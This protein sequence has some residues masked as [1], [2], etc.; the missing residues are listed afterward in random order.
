MYWFI[1]LPLELRREEDRDSRGEKRKRNNRKKWREHLGTFFYSNNEKSL[2]VTYYQWLIQAQTNWQNMYRVVSHKLGLKL[3]RI[4][5]I[6]SLKT[7][8]WYQLKKDLS[9]SHL[10]EKQ[11]FG[12]DSKSSW[13]SSDHFQLKGKASRVSISR[14]SLNCSAFET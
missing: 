3:K 5:C 12:H 14:G 4:W 13:R 7:L 9:L 8:I 11:F 10:Q 1:V 6:L 2:L